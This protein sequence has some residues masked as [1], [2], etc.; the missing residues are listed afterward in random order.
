M[1][2]SSPR[3]PRDE[4]FEELIIHE[5]K[6]LERHLNACKCIYKLIVSFKNENEKI[7]NSLLDDARNLVKE[8]IY[9]IIRRMKLALSNILIVNNESYENFY[10]FLNNSTFSFSNKYFYF[11]IFP[12]EN[13]AHIYIHVALMYKE[14]VLKKYSFHNFENL[15]IFISEYI[16][17]SLNKISHFS[18]N[19]SDFT[20]QLF[21]TY[22]KDTKY[23][24][25]YSEIF[26][27]K[28]NDKN[29]STKKY[30]RKR[31]SVMF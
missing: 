1:K 30:K 4:N 19:K 14:K 28:H 24:R 2:K 17:K 5:R 12:E 9:M 15:K 16:L 25:T 29:V 3:T 22:V 18:E 23:N 21:R 20:K 10:L 8:R 27:T 13:L 26:K 11:Y 7:Y 6:I 31:M